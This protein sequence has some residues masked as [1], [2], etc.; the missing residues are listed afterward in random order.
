MRFFLVKQ[1]QQPL[2]GEITLSGDKSIACRS[3]IISAISQGKTVIENFPPS[4]DCLYAIKSFQ[5][6]V[7]E[8]SQNAST[9][10]VFGKGLYYGLKKP[11]RPIFVG[12]S[13]TALRLTLGILG[14]VS[15]HSR[16]FVVIKL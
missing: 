7:V 1:A 6:L 11:K 14:G 9:V 13:G 8:I 12:D 10:T 2:Q 3:I 16:F 15:S 4:K 5:R